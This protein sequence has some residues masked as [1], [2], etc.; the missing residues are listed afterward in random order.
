MKLNI[1][2]KTKILKNN[3]GQCFLFNWSSYTVKNIHNECTP[4]SF[5]T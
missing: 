3:T 4:E 2:T 5:R 1:E